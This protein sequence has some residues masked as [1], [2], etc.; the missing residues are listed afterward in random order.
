MITSVEV[1]IDVVGVPEM[2]EDTWP[3]AVPSAEDNAGNAVGWLV[4]AEVSP[5]CPFDDCA[6]RGVSELFSS[7][8]AVEGRLEVVGFREGLGLD[9]G[10]VLCVTAGGAGAGA[11]LVV[12]LGGEGGLWVLVVGAGAGAGAGGGCWGEGF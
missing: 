6:G 12:V 8:L 10:R 11:R 2:S 3:E 4:S 1:N 7:G 5:V 9:A